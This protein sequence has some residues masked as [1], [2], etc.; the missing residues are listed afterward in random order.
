MN[1]IDRSHRRVAI[2]RNAGI[3][4]VLVGGLGLGG[5]A[6]PFV[7][8]TL[9]LWDAV[10]GVSLIATAITGKGTNEHALSLVMNEDCR[11]VDGLLSADRDICEPYGSA[12]TEGDFRGLSGAVD[13]KSSNG[14]PRGYAYSVRG[15]PRL[16]YDYAA[17][18]MPAEEPAPVALAS[19]PTAVALASA[20]IAVALASI[21]ELPS[22]WLALVEEDEAGL[23]AAARID[24]FVLAAL[25]PA[26]PGL[27]PPPTT[28]PAAA[29]VPPAR[30]MAVP[31]PPH[32]PDRAATLTSTVPAASLVGAALDRAAPPWPARPDGERS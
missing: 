15:R 25:T 1:N 18:W 16:G 19:A 26:S 29:P 20:P 9:T 30:P 2:W 27:W 3:A 13:L 28:R 12:A 5:C 14:P 17:L 21:D 22:A 31:L 23:E 8:G 24:P 32:K 11:F 10:T 7:A 6:V 4:A